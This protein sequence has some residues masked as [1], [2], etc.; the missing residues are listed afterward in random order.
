MK[1]LLFVSL[2]SCIFFST[3]SEETLIAESQHKHSASLQSVSL[4]RCLPY[5]FVNLIDKN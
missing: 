5:R 4:L 3:P 1:S 2:V